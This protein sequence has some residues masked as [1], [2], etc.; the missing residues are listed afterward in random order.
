M[1]KNISR[2]ISI[3]QI[4][5]PIQTEFEKFQVKFNHAFN[6]D[7]ELINIVNQYILKKTGKQIRPILTIL[8]AKSQG[9]VNENTYR[10]AIAMEMLHTASLIHDDVVD[11]SNERR[12]Q[13]SVN[14][15]WNN[16]VSILVGDYLLSQALSIANETESHKILT[17][18]TQLGKKLSEGELL[19]ISN[20][21]NINC[22]EEKYIDVI[23]KKTAA[24]FETCTYSGAISVKYNELQTKIL[25]KF[26]EIYGICFQIKDDIFDYISSEKKLGKPV[27]NDIREGKIT[28]PLLYA[29][30]VSQQKE[31]Y[32]DIIR[33]KDFTKENIEKIINFAISNGGIEYAK[34]KMEKYKQEALS[35]LKNIENEKIRKSLELV[36]Q[37]T[38][39]REN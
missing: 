38:I 26:G 25:E 3:E 17:K 35:I 21:K 18:I 33:R 5:E 15:K 37:H 39:E 24:L 9:E 28:L 36:L 10:C 11:E 30:N 19:Q 23:R 13:E 16:K 6:S 2:M 12:G 32:I 4:K 31:E 7:N 1:H 27:G 34:Q 22:D 14:A 29:L 20:V 8:A